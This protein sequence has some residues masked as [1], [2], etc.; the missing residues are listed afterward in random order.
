MSL[1]IF[2]SLNVGRVGVSLKLLDREEVDVEFG[3]E[4]ESTGLSSGVDVGL[5]AGE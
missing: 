3:T 2:R 1:K 4:T 5:V